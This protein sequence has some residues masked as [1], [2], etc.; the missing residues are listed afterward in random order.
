MRSGRVTTDPGR[1]REGVRVGVVGRRDRGG[2][3]VTKRQYRN[4]DGHR[5]HGGSV[6]FGRRG[7]IVCEFS[8]WA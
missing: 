8:G 2:P 7:R 4:R 3:N 6:R 1:G 5:E